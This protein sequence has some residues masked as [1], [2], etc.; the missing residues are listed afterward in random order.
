M[1]RKSCCR[2][3]CKLCAQSVSADATVDAGDARLRDEAPIACAFV[4]AVH[5]EQ[6]AIKMQ[7][8]RR[9]P[10]REV[11]AAVRMATRAEKCAGVA[12][13]KQRRADEARLRMDVFGLE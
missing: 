5:L 9:P 4:V 7:R 2:R 6:A 1:L 13:L 8:D 10:R 11:A 12:F 3:G